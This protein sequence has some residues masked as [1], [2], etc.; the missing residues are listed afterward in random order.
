LEG[1]NSGLN[2]LDGQTPANLAGIRNDGH[3]LLLL[4]LMPLMPLMP[5]WHN[6]ATVRIEGMEV[7]AK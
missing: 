5:H 2:A 4:P 1:Y 6:A 3:E 7:S